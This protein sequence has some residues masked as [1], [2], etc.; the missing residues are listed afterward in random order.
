MKPIS[1]QQIVKYGI[2]VYVP[3]KEDFNKSKIEI[4]YSPKNPLF[5]YTH[6]EDSNSKI[7]EKK[8][9]LFNKGTLYIYNTSKPLDKGF[10]QIKITMYDNY[11]TKL[12]EGSN[13]YGLL[14]NKDN[15]YIGVPYS[16]FGPILLT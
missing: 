7:W 6:C 2:V 4:F 3:S 8:D 15:L 13:T 10:Y 11:Q 5:S 14:N 12:I 16:T 9:T 1:P